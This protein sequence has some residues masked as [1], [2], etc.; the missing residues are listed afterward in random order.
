MLMAKFKKAD[1][2][3]T[4]KEKT[5]KVFDDAKQLLFE[6][7]KASGLDISDIADADDE[8]IILFKR[9]MEIMKTA[10]DLAIAQAAQLDK[11][12]MLDAIFKEVAVITADV[13][14]IDRKID[15]A[16][17]KKDKE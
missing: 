15:I 10:E 4:L 13:K 3:K 12:D 9:Y 14:G 17:K 7:M 1:E 6:A 16:L 2:A 5:E 8:T 11:I